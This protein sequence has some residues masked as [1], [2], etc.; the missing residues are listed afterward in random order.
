MKFIRV[1]KKSLESLIEFASEHMRNLYPQTTNPFRS[2]FVNFVE[3]SLNDYREMRSFFDMDS[4]V[5]ID[6][7]WVAVLYS[8]SNDTVSRGAEYRGPSTKGYKK[9]WNVNITSTGKMWVATLPKDKPYG[10]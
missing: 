4:H 1:R 9:Y 3:I 6:S 10:G 7:V 8:E 5:D 2:S